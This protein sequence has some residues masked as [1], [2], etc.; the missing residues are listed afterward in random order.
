MFRHTETLLRSLFWAVVIVGTSSRPIYAQLPVADAF[1]RLSQ[2][3]VTGATVI[4]HGFQPLDT[5]GN[6]LMPLAEAVQ[7]RLRDQDSSEV[8]L[9]DYELNDAGATGFYNTANSNLPAAGSVDQTGHVVLLWDWAPESHDTSG[10]W[11]DSVGDA[12]F[13]H[14]VGLGLV[15]PRNPPSS[16]PLH[17]IGHSF[18]TGVT[19]EVVERLATWQIPVANLTYLDPHDFDQADIIVDEDQQ[20]FTLGRPSGY[21]ATVWSNVEFADAYY[22]TRGQQGSGVQLFTS[23]PEGRAIPGAAN[24]WLRTVRSITVRFGA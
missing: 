17:M 11:V 23:D 13:S 18:G 14:L 4:T 15:H 2:Q 10:R 7:D 8:W 6:S 3:R 21:G 24:H 5:F 9:L 12:L 22:Q 19:S 16:V 1:A 20:I